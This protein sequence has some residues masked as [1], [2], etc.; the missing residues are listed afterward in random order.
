MLEVTS[1]L[2]TPVPGILVDA[3]DGWGTG[4]DGVYQTR[5][6]VGEDRFSRDPVRV[7]IQPRVVQHVVA[8]LVRQRTAA[9]WGTGEGPHT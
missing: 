5:E 1:I 9:A 2:K 8:S 4:G 7:D 3:L 6:A